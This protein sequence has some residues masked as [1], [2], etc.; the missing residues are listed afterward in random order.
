MHLPLRY[1]EMT[2]PAT[3]HEEDALARTYD[4]RLMRRLLVYIRPYLPLVVAAL[5][6]LIIEGVLQLA[7]PILTQRVIDKAIPARDSAAIIAATV[8]YAATLRTA[9][10]QL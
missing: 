5:A 8:L 2:T 4:A 9:F 6:L 10:F 3:L 7:G 1:R